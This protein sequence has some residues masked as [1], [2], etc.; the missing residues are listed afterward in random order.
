M[1][2]LSA[3]CCW[4]LELQELPPLPP[5]PPTHT[6]GF[7]RVKRDTVTHRQAVIQNMA[8]NLN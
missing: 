8:Y 2:V 7:P 3:L 1:N 6:L 5:P 4:F